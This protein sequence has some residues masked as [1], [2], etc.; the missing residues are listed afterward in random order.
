MMQFYDIIETF[1]FVKNQID[2]PFNNLLCNPFEP[3]FPSLYPLLLF[4]LVRNSTF[5]LEM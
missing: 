2:L 3:N 1:F 4:A 5:F